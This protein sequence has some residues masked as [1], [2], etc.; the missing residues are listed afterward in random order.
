MKAE[1]SGK[2]SSIIFKKFVL[3][4]AG[5]S[6]SP[7]SLLLDFDLDFDRDLLRIAVAFNSSSGIPSLT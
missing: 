5:S 4:P 1:V 7:C 3:I 6:N 2:F